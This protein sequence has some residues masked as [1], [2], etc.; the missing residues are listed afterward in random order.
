MSYY[1]QAMT[2]GIMPPTVPTMPTTPSYT[3][4]IA[5][6]G[7]PFY[8]PPNLPPWW[9]ALPSTVAPVPNVLYMVPHVQGPTGQ[10]QPLIPLTPKPQSPWYLPWQ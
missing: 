6:Q 1:S 7:P 10:L 4:P 8:G 3:T 9:L 5:P 2:G